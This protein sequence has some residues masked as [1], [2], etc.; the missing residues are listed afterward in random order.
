MPKKLYI[1]IFYKKTFL[2]KFSCDLK[3]LRILNL[4][5]FFLYANNDLQKS[6]HARNEF[7]KN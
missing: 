4:K 7:S 2:Q 1:E 3:Y 6:K 5:Q